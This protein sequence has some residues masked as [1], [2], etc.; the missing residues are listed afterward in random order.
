MDEVTVADGLTALL[1]L[2]ASTGE[3]LGDVDRATL[4]ALAAETDSADTFL[5]REVEALG[6]DLPIWPL[7]QKPSPMRRTPP[8]RPSI[9]SC[10]SSSNCPFAGTRALP[11]A[12]G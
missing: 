3:A 1:C 7:T 8:P 9:S 5:L 6:A 12:R 10:A 11:S 2:A 4:V